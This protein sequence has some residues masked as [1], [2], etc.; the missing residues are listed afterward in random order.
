MYLILCS[1]AP[2]RQGSRLTSIKKKA[3]GTRCGGGGL[4]WSTTS[5]YLNAITN[6]LFL[7]V[8]AHLANRASSESDRD[9]Y[10]G[11]AQ[12]EWDWFAAQ[13]FI[14]ANYTINDGLLENCQ[15]NGQTV[16]VS[17]PLSHLRRLHAVILVI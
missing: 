14:G 6:E 5:A 17:K 3:W 16:Y 1:R 11:W 4:Q 12:K 15:N 8:A 2:C 10:I 13:G 7:S 9:T